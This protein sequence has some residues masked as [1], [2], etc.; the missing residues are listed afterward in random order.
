MEAPKYLS[1][2]WPKL[3]HS[4]Q[5]F[6]NGL[7]VDGQ[8]QDETI[9]SYA[10][11]LLEPSASIMGK[12]R[13]TINELENLAINSQTATDR[14]VRQGYEVLDDFVIKHRDELERKKI[15]QKLLLEL[16]FHE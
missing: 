11:L 13:R 5:L 3:S 6:I 7:C 12:F 8:E 16:I 10:H 15:I 4:S 9:A 14:K 2:I 1:G